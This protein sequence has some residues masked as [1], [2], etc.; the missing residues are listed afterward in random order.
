MALGIPYVE[1][2]SRDPGRAGE[3]RS[4]Y[5]QVL[6]APSAVESTDRG[7]SAAVQIGRN[8][9]ID[10]SGDRS[11]GTRLRRTPQ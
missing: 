10:V 1:F 3:Y 9:V 8:Q 7:P 11:A 4:L 2:L 5:D 6:G